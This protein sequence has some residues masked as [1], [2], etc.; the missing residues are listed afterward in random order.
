MCVY[1]IDHVY[2]FHS[3][4]YPVH[5]PSFPPLLPPP[6]S[7]SL[8]NFLTFSFLLAYLPF[9][10]SSSPTENSTTINKRLTYLTSLG[11]IV[12]GLGT[13]NTLGKI[14][15]IGRHEIKK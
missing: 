12:P 4:R 7:P 2:H 9:F 1:V 10:H 8:H 11:G 15:K 3:H 14:G 13:I 5:S 6:P